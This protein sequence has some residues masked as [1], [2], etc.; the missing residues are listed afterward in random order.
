MNTFEDKNRLRINSN[1]N[2]SSF[3]D[4]INEIVISI[5]RNNYRVKVLNDKVLK[6]HL[7]YNKRKFEKKSIFTLIH[8]KDKKKLKKYFKKIRKNKSR[9]TQE[10]RI[11]DKQFNYKWFKV[12]NINLNSNREENKLLLILDDITKV[13]KLE[14]NLKKNEVELKKL[15]K[16]VPEI[17]FWKVFLPKKKEEAIYMSYEML[18]RVMNN[19][20]EYLFWKNNDLYYLGCN[21][22]YAKFIG[23]DK[24]EDIL[25]KKDEDLN[26]DSTIFKDFNNE[27]REVLKTEEKQ[28]NLIKSIYLNNEEILF[29]INRIP[30]F[31]SKQEIVGLLVTYQDI[32]ELKKTQERYRRDKD[33]LESI[34]ETSPIGILEV[35]YQKRKLTY[36]NPKLMKI[37]GYSQG[38]VAMEYLFT[39]IF[40]KENYKTFFVNS[41]NNQIEFKVFDKQGKIKWLSGKKINQYNKSGDLL[42][43]RLW[44]EDVTEK[45]MYERLIYELNII[46]LNF[47]TDVKKNIQLLLET[48]CKLINAEIVV[49]VHNT[50]EEEGHIFQLI[51]STGKILQYS[52]EIFKN[53]FHSNEVLEE[54]HDI[55]QNFLDLDI[56]KYAKTDPFIKNFNA[57]GCYGK[58]INLD[59]KVNNAICAYYTE[60]LIL[61]HHEQLVLFLV[62]A[63]IEIEQKRWQVQLHL[64]EQN[65]LKTELFTRTSHELKTPL[66]SIKGFADLLLK[67]HSP[68]LNNEIITIL[69]DIKKGSNR[70]EAIINSLLKSTKLEQGKIELNKS[71]EDLSFLIRFCVKEMRGMT[72][73]R[74]QKVN[75]NIDDKLI[76]VFDKERIY[77]V[78]NNILLNAIKYTPPSGEI[79]ISSNKK[80]NEII[81]SIEDNGIG[82]TE[83]EKR[84]IFKQFGKIER[85]GRGWDVE[86]E[87]S[88]L[89]LYISKRIIELH[90][91]KISVESEGRNKGS[92]FSFSLPTKRDN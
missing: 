18:Q 68:S 50:L 64:E 89:G 19:I 29:N 37:L 69:E 38:N 22:L 91:G 16:L 60:N 13:K 65:K 92:K 88:G 6:D 9:K 35:D 26:L 61:S 48:C 40:H 51:T 63:A 4:N 44:V 43:F 66:I 67:V 31:N 53:K 21:D 82:L 36:I 85:Y 45:K 39:R 46:F 32:T 90:G 59:D 73:L 79:S 27:E 10:I 30:L 2:F 20:P 42:N 56:S 74:H 84:M 12:K 33:L 1:G 23:V 8:S 28:T 24:P 80:N 49:Y 47:T 78:V 71:T 25:D 57:K 83:G 17:K 5:D 11:R 7:G 41:E 86:I 72:N 14:H 3:L 15:I 75:I 54:E 55:I 70:M 62:S 81:I 77:E 52:E 87:G 58:I 76:A 34:M